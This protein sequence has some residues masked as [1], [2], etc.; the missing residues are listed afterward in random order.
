MDPFPLYSVQGLS[1]LWI[2]LLLLATLA[3]VQTRE[4]TKEEEEG[5]I[6]ESFCSLFY[7]NGLCCADRAI[8]F[9]IRL[10]KS[11]WKRIREEGIYVNIVCKWDVCVCVSMRSNVL[12]VC[13]AWEVR[14]GNMMRENGIGIRKNSGSFQWFK[15]GFKQN[16]SF[17]EM[18][19]YFQTLLILTI[20]LLLLRSSLY[21]FLLLVYR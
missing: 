17:Y 18:Q 6:S 7:L 11:E 4:W 3:M 19:K 8:N 12:N 2:I 20:F 21:S 14:W 5:T 9:K 13:N 15:K 1:S 16:E 10:G